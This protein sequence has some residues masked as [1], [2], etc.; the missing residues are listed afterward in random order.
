MYTYY[1]IYI[2][3]TAETIRYVA[4]EN[5]A[6]CT[7][8][9]KN[10][11]KKKTKKDTRNKQASVVSWPC[12]DTSALDISPR[13][14]VR[15]PLCGICYLFAVSSPNLL[16]LHVAQTDFRGFTL[17]LAAEKETFFSCAF[18]LDIWSATLNYEKNDPETVRT[19]YDCARYRGQRS[20]CSTAKTQTNATHSRPTCERNWRVSLRRFS[21]TPCT[22]TRSGLCMRCAG[23]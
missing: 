10:N 8:T 23:L 12:R 15:W 5:I 6:T 19:K 3:W 16:F 7:R 17:L 22:C 18:K 14:R 20:F 4:Y 2:V 9:N 1:V 21:D 13:Q 11:G